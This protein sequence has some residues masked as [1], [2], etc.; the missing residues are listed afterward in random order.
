MSIGR[1]GSLPITEIRPKRWRYSDSVMTWKEFFALSPQLDR[2]FPVANS[3]SWRP[4][5][6]V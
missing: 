2:Y 4:V 5:T 3:A 6:G 1:P